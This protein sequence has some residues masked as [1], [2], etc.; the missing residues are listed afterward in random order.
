[1][2]L[3]FLVSV[4]LIGW[5]W[6]NVEDELFRRYSGG[7]RMMDEMEFASYWMHFDRDGDGNVTKLEFDRTWKSDGL[8]DPERAPFFFIELDRVADEVLNAE[9]FTHMFH[10]FDEDGDG[11]ILKSEFDFNWK[12]LFDD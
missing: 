7:D 11:K 1:M 2:K 3:L 10:I 4:A 6:A 9:D 8:N 12:G 5:A